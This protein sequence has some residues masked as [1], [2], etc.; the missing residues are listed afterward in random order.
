M[1]ILVTGGAGY[2]GSETARALLSRGYEVV[3]YDNLSTGFREAVPAGAKFVFGDVRDESL[4]GRVIK[5]LGIE[6]VMHFAAKIVVPESFERPLEYYDTNLQGGLRT[7]AA[8]RAHG[9]KHFV[10]SSTAAVY[11]ETGDEPVHEFSPLNPINP[12][13]A[14][15]LMMERV[16]ADVSSSG[17][18][19]YVALRYFNVAGAAEDGSN[20]QRREMATHLA[21]VVAR[22]AVGALPEVTVFGEDYPTPDGT[23]I[24]D[25]IH[26]VDL[27]EAHVKALE[28]LVGG[29]ESVALNCGYGRGV[30]VKEVLA[31]FQRLLGREL[32]VKKGPRRIGDPARIV[33]SVGKIQ[34]VLGWRPRLDDLSTICRSALEW[35]RRFKA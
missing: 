19:R 33:A 12:Y 1:K 32:S 16:L 7:L 25:Y 22:A 21:H 13:G 5:D 26:V 20:G 9:V 30:S 35:E 31:E 14:S 10:F 6:A 17:G 24:R 18:P 4:V 28:Y 23:C 2:I 27:A 11:G 34:E 15:K 3:I 29:G 8:A